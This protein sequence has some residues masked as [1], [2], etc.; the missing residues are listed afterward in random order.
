[1]CKPITDRTVR[2]VLVQGGLELSNGGKELVGDG[3]GDCG[4]DNDVY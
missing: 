1:M 2:G 4:G 3:C